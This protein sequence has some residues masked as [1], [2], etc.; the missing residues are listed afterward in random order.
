MPELQ[1]RKSFL[2][3]IIQNLGILLGFGEYL[4]NLLI[5]WLIEINYIMVNYIKRNNAIYCF[6][7]RPN[8]KNSQ[9]I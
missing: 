7:R 2:I 1:S 8:S 9:L 4:S 6:I 5:F 3:L